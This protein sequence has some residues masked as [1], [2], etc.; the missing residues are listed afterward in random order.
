MFTSRELEP[1]LRRPLRFV[2]VGVLNTVSGLAV[3]FA[4]KWLLH[5]PDVAANVVGYAAGLAISFVL[6]GRWTFQYKGRLG[7]ALPRFAGVV[8]TAYLANLTVVIGAIHG[9]GINGY[10][11]QTLG[12]VPYTLAT[13]FGMKHFV[14]AGS[15]HAGVRG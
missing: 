12:V 1:L 9:F 11:A 2:L 14:Y 5:M 7:N 8:A 6:N 15:A 4:L 13:Y 3:I 10:V